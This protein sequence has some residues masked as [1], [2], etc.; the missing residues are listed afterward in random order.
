MPSHTGSPRRHQALIR[1]QESRNEGK[2]QARTFTG[3][4]TGKT[5]QDRVNSFRLASLNNSS[6]LWDIGDFSVV[7]YLILG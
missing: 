7:W 5:R 2:S 6:G 3:G 1:R 4:S